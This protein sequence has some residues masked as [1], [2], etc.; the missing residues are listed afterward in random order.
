MRDRFTEIEIKRMNIFNQPNRSSSRFHPND[1]DR[2]GDVFKTKSIQQQIAIE[3]Y[4]KTIHILKQKFN[5]SA[6]DLSKF[7]EEYFG[8][9]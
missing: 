7:T 2:P 4:K 3:S 9:M 8:S 5:F 1:H 6:E